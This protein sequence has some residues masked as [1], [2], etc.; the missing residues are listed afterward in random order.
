[1]ASGFEVAESCDHLSDDRAW[2]SWALGVLADEASASAPTPIVKLP[3]RAD[4]NVDLYL[5]DES[6][7]ATGSLKH[8]LA[9][10]LLVHAIASG[11]VRRGTTLVEA[12]SGSTAI[13]EAYFAR[14]LGLPYVAVMPD[15]STARPAVEAHGG[16]CRLVRQA[17]E[18][19]GM[20]EQLVARNPNCHYIDQFTFAER[21]S[22][23]HGD[24]TIAAELFE[25]L[26]TE[27]DAVPDWIV[28]GAGTG[29]TATTLGRHARYHRLPTRLAV[30]DPD[31]SAYFP[32]YAER[33]PEL[34]CCLTGSRIEGIGRPRIEPSFLPSVVDRMLHVADASSIAA[35]R[36]AADVL[37]R[38]VGGS[39][40]TNL[41]GALNIAASLRDC[42]RRQTVVTIICDG[43]ERY[44]NT[45]YNDDWLVQEGLD[46]ERPLRELRE[47]L[48]RPT[49]VPV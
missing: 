8:R 42:D 17:G 41:W 44:V 26:L 34:G 49:S 25:Q 30:V 48:R 33:T 31:G 3:L 47:L 27:H 28:V 10:A 14:L 40:G 18:V 21:A 11:W 12:S 1:M 4:W 43:G 13:S 37:G 45:Y 5:K 36:W 22:N 6:A 32:A 29:G 19:Y 9:R 38:A 2:S 16:R 35:M 23:W 24:D 15:K 20:A 39:T 7:H 46:I